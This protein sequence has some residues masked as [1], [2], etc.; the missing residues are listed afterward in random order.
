MNDMKM[1]SQIS[2]WLELFIKSLDKVENAEKWK[3]ELDGSLDSIIA[4][5]DLIDDIWGGNSP[6]GKL[7]D[8]L[9]AIWGSYV[10]DCIQRAYEGKW[11]INEEGTWLYKIETDNV[12]ITLPIFSWVHKRFTGSESIYE[13]IAEIEG[14]LEQDEHTD[15]AE[16]NFALTAALHN[17]YNSQVGPSDSIKV[18]EDRV[19]ALLNFESTLPGILADESEGSEAPIDVD[20]VIEIEEDT[21]LI[22]IYIYIKGELSEE[23][24]SRIGIQTINVNP[25][26]T[27]GHFEVYTTKKNDQHFLRYRASIYAKSI[28]KNIEHVIND[29]FNNASENCMQGLNKILVNTES[30]DGQDELRGL[31]VDLICYEEFLAQNAKAKR[32]SFEMLKTIAVE[33]GDGP[34]ADAKAEP[35]LLGLVNNSTVVYFKE[36]TSCKYRGAN[37]EGQYFKLNNLKA[38]EDG[39]VEL[40]LEFLWYKWKPRSS[41]GKIATQRESFVLHTNF[42]GYAVAELA[43][44]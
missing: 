10:A 13:R 30:T 28:E 36:G 3:Q 8:S 14:H 41:W 1:R 11:E 6:A 37:L 20:N 26:L 9:V 12:L 29:L 5:D 21:G 16:T 27:F 32:I 15:E 40:I 35:S 34:N 24:A 4:L 38:L 33:K 18:S 44:N 39:Q 42:H 25:L 19:R 7:F 43:R 22:S 17:W 31:P 2:T 23:V